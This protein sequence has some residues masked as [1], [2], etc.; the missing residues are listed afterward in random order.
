MN[1]RISLPIKEGERTPKLKV[2]G[3]RL[4]VYHQ[5]DQFLVRGSLLT[6][7]LMSQGFQMS[8]LQATFRKFYDRYNDLVY[9]YNLSLGHML[10]DMFHTNRQ[11]VLDSDL[12]YGSYRLPNLEKGLTAGV[13]DRQGMPTLLWHLMPPLIYS[14]VRVRPFS[15]FVFPI[16]LISHSKIYATITKISCRQSIYKLI[17]SNVATRTFFFFYLKVIL[18]GLYEHAGR[19]FNLS[20]IK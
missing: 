11:A 6:N 19:F 5:N 18:R 1:I 13:I 14:E 8:H 9:Q 2:D 15:G 3:E 12:E 4:L 16:G 20:Y 7:K 17:K 10:F